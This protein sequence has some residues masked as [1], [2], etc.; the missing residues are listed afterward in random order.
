MFPKVV[1]L[2]INTEPTETVKIGKSFLYDFK[3]NQFV[4]QNGKNVVVEGIDALKMW[5]EKTLRTEKF[6]FKIYER[7]N[8]KENEYG[9]Q[10]K[11]LIGTKYPAAFIE[12]ELRREIT[13]ALKKHPVIS[14]ISNLTVDRNDG[15]YNINFKVILRDGVTFTQEVSV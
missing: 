12:S 3:T 5:I 8:D 10:L 6:R 13:E 4:M 14:G 2:E 11:D 1:Q 15:T 7:V 9:V